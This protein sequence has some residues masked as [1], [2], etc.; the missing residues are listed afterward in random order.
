MRLCS[1]RVVFFSWKLCAD[2]NNFPNLTLAGIEAHLLCSKG[3]QCNSQYTTKRLS[4]ALYSKHTSKFIDLIIYLERSNYVS[5]HNRGYTVSGLV[6]KMAIKYFTIF[7]LVLC[8]LSSIPVEC[9][10]SISYF[11]LEIRNNG[12]DLGSRLLFFPLCSRS[13]FDL[14]VFVATPLSP[15][16]KDYACHL[17]KIR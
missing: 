12:E 17:L 5:K 11:A 6:V 15:R 3:H 10:Y 1:A 2:S 4:H 8:S 16:M 7:V 14:V 13:F 9:Q